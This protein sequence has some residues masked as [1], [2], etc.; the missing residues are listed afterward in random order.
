[1]YLASSGHICRD[2]S[3]DIIYVT[4]T[5]SFYHLLLSKTYF[6]ERKSVVSASH[7]MIIYDGKK[8]WEKIDT[9]KKCGSLT[10]NNLLSND[11][12]AP[13]YHSLL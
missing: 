8:D 3:K 4:K 9:F 7:G 1:M 10:P 6:L 11:L 12:C 2:L 5:I 13:F